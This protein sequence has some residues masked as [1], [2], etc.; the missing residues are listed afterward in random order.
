MT[1][2]ARALATMLTTV[3]VVGCGDADPG[4]DLR[5]VVDRNRARWVSARPDAY[6]YEVAR[7]CF[8]PETHLGP[9]IVTVVGGQVVERR[10]SGSGEPVDEEVAPAF[11]TVEGLFDILLDAIDAHAFSVQV[12]WDDATGVPLHFFIDYAQAIA[13]EESDYTVVALPVEG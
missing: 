13:D 2:L 4:S 6:S 11:P 8:C 10:Y 3:L 12:E 7:S 9:V 1:R 5:Q